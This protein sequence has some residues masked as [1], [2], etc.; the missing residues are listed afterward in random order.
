MDPSQRVSHDLQRRA[1]TLLGA[2]SAMLVAVTLASEA[3]FPKPVRR[4]SSH[5]RAR[6]TLAYVTRYQLTS[7]FTR[8]F[9]MPRE[10]FTK[11][12][13]L[14]RPRLERDA[15][16][17]TQSSGG[18]I[19]PEVRLAV[20]LRILGGASYLDLMMVFRIGR[21]SV[22]QV[23]FST[24]SAVLFVMPMP[25]VPF[26]DVVAMK[27]L[28]EGFQS[29]LTP[30]NILWG[31]IAALD[32]IS[33][34]IKKPLDRYYP[35]HYFTR[36]GFYALSVQAMCDSSY[37]FLYMSANCV[38]STHESLAWHAQRLA[39]SLSTDFNWGNTG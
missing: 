36:K 14:L 20:L 11:L 24:I 6:P 12:L 39:Q 18:R 31:C 8:C 26:D 22:Y 37:R 19:E 33:L 13:R 27:K 5:R 3:A 35:R 15:D 23:V 9:R 17:A 38:G 21:S 2:C 1:M 10:V 28:V 16:M 7:E 34:P 25:G 30:R 32:G 4:V 29:S